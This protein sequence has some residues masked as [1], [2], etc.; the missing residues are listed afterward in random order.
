MWALGIESLI[1]FFSY[2]IVYAWNWLNKM[3]YERNS[4]DYFEL[5]RT[6]V[7]TL[8]FIRSIFEFSTLCEP[9]NFYT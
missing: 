9:Y 5:E 2:I 7:L 3:Q 4:I 6:L 1:L 8:K